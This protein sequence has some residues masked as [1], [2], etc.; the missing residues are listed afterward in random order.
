MTQM[1]I[2][3][4]SLWIPLFCS[5]CAALLVLVSIA[6]HVPPQPDE[7]TRAHLFQLLIVIQLPFVAAFAA[8]AD[9]AH[10]RRPAT[11]LGVQAAAVAAALVPVWIAGY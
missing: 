7:D 9:W 1:Q 3:R 11:L 6:Q 2:H 10:W 4:I 8:T 5:A